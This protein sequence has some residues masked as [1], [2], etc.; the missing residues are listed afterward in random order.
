MLLDRNKLQVSKN[1]KSKATIWCF[2]A[3]PKGLEKCCFIN[4]LTILNGT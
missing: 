3:N 4:L 1:Y 2:D